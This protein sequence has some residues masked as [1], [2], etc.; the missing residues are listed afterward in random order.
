VRPNEMKAIVRKKQKRKLIEVDQRDLE[1]RVR[2]F[3]VPARKINRYM[4]EKGI[5][6]SSLY[7]ESPTAC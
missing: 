2:G 7:P 6:E 1:F 5:A 4:R 3:E